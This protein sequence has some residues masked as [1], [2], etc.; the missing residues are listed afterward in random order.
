MVTPQ[1]EGDGKL[2]EPHGSSTAVPQPC[3][4]QTIVLNESCSNIAYS[5][6]MKFLLL[7]HL[8]RVL[9]TTWEDPTFVFYT[10]VVAQFP[11][12]TTRLTLRDLNVKEGVVPSASST[13]PITKLEDLEALYHQHGIMVVYLPSPKRIRATAG[14]ILQRCFS[15]V[16]QFRSRMN[17]NLCVY[18]IG[19]TSCPPLRFQ[20]YKE[21]NYTCMTLLHVCEHVGIAQMLEAALI[22]SHVSQTG[23]RNERLGGEG[24]PSSHR[25]P[26]HFVYI[27]GARA[28]CMKSIGWCTK[29]V[30]LLPRA[31]MWKIDLT[32]SAASV[33]TVGPRGSKNQGTPKK[34]RTLNGV[35]LWKV[36]FMFILVIHC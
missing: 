21:L 29:F 19:L 16:D 28:D 30:L 3:D 5:I 35:L 9:S 33:H 13:P 14:T 36:C 7:K 22:A 17:K 31:S 2:Q 20:F 26:F 4:L 8:I 34:N 25:E 27:V 12:S 24:P 18:K 10:Q 11:R 1:G 32:C 15:Q 6:T 23:C